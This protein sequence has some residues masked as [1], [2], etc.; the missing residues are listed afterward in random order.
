M[1]FA[2]PMGVVSLLGG[3]TVE[4]PPSFSYY[5]ACFLWCLRVAL[6]VV[7]LVVSSVFVLFWWWS[8]CLL[9]E[10][11]GFLFFSFDCTW[12][13]LNQYMPDMLLSMAFQ[14]KE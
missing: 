4:P 2:T 1:A 3:L 13:L 8:C 11:R 9:H 14:K 6:A 5:E 7:A 12:F 10:C